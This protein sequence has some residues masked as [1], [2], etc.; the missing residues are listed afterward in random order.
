M[1]FNPLDF[2][3]EEDYPLNPKTIGEHIRKR[4]MDLGLEQKDL[5][6]IIGVTESSIWNWEN[7]W[8]PSKRYMK[9]IEGFFWD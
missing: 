9:K 4:R 7:G 8:N 6:K 1:G 3:S 5:A 2:L